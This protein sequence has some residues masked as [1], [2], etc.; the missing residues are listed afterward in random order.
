[1]HRRSLLRPAALLPAALLTVAVAAGC[2]SDGDE[3]GSSDGTA[4]IDEGSGE[5]TQPTSAAEG[6][7]DDAVG[8]PAPDRGTIEVTDLDQQEYDQLRDRAQE[9]SGTA[10]VTP[11]GGTE[12]C[13]LVEAGDQATWTVVAAAPDGQDPVA[14]TVEMTYAD[15]AVGATPAQG[16]GSRWIRAEWQSPA[17]GDLDDGTRLSTVVEVGQPTAPTLAECTIEGADPL[18]YG[19]DEGRADEG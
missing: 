6:G 4:A 10:C 18:A 12:V 19:C 7:V 5:A 3:G 11:D 14:S 8:A 1:M 9:A 13:T 2:G 17:L 16:T 15:R